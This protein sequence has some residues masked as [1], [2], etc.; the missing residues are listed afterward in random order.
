VTEAQR[1]ALETLAESRF[2]AKLHV[3]TARSLERR[4]LIESKGDGW[5]LT[6]V[7][8]NCL[9]RQTV[10]ARAQAIENEFPA[11]LRERLEQVLLWLQFTKRLD[12]PYRARPLIQA[13]LI[14]QDDFSLGNPNER[15]EQRVRRE[16]EDAIQIVTEY[17]EAQEEAIRT[18]GH[19]GVTIEAEKPNPVRAAKRQ[20]RDVEV[21]TED[22]GAV[23]LSA[24]RKRRRVA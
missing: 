7:G 2:P 17:A 4:R 9:R 15:V 22:G 14:G 8:R 1:A 5:I 20:Q 21:A 6:E 13:L 10:E 23:S 24:Y 16:V 18:G 3:G 12:W 11:S 19:V